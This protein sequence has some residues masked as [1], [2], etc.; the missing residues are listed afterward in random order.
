MPSAFGGAL[1]ARARRFPAAVQVALRSHAAASKA[2]VHIVDSLT[3]GRSPTSDRASAAV[4]VVELGGVRACSVV[5]MLKESELIGVVQHLTARRF[6]P[7]PTSR[8]SWLRISPRRPSS[9][10]RTRGCSASCANRWQQ[11]TATAEVLKV[12]SPARRAT[13]QPVFEAMLENATQAL[14]GAL[15]H[16]AAARWRSSADRC[17]ACSTCTVSALFER[18]FA[19]WSLPT[20]RAIRWSASWSTKDLYSHR[21]L[22]NGTLL[23]CEAISRIVGFRRYLGRAHG[24][25]RADDEGRR[26]H[27]R[28]RH[29]SGRKCGRSPTSR[30]SWSRTLPPRPSSPSRMRGCSPNCGSRWSSR[31]LLPTCCALFPV[32]RA[33]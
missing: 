25:L 26:M 2:V 17:P 12:I 7:L 9:P 3:I 1:A 32:R 13:L 22:A 6:A 10:S 5:P 29:S 20:M 4:A 31:P 30:S 21:R 16:A 24:S 33:I 23:H 15:R 27:R 19:S 28:V 14:R 8:L 18:G 11:Q